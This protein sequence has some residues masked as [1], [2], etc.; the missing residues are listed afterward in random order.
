[1]TDFISPVPIVRR[2]YSGRESSG[3]PGAEYLADYASVFDEHVYDHSV[4][5]NR[6]SLPYQQEV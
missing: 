1:M 5:F 4:R 6:L 3:A 2:L